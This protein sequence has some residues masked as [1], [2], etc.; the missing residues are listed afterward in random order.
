MQRVK[1][2]TLAI[3]SLIIVGVLASLLAPTPRGN[4]WLTF[5]AYLAVALGTAIAFVGSSILFI[6][7]LGGFTDKFKRVYALICIALVA[8]GIAF[9]QLPLTFYLVD[10]S[11]FWKGSG[12]LVSGLFFFS[13]LILVY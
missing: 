4:D 7:G 8:L 6:M 12:S 3:V 1:L 13:A 11:G 10:F 5:H 2:T 9:V